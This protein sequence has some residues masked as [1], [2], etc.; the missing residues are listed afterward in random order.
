MRP[1]WLFEADVFGPAAEPVKAEVRRQGM[2]CHVIRQ[3]MLALGVGP[4]PGGG[5][6]A[7]NACVIFCG[8]FP[9]W[10]FLRKNR[11]W[12]PGG[13]CSADNLACTTY[14]GHFGPHLLNQ[15][16]TILPSAEAVRHR[17]ALY[18]D[19]G[20]GGEVFV[21]PNGCQKLFTGRRVAKDD[22]AAA[23]GPA[24]YDPTTL[25]LVARPRDIAREWRLAVAEG[26]V[27]AASQYLHDGAAEV[28]PGCPDEVRA[29]AAEALAE[30]RWEPDD[31]F[32]MDV[33]ESEGRLYLLELNGFSCA[34]LYACDARPVVAAASDLAVREWRRRTGCP[35]P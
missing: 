27:I 32:M 9:C 16:Y 10:H 2:G 24:R 1:T 25:V 8:T 19:L 26:A 34:A 4:L 18:E 22:F 31:I 11:D 15:R 20:R 13:W 30:A 33:C 6:L 17:D 5:Q 12:V 35:A 21:R 28:A 14:Y 29:F 3:P 23:L 7:D